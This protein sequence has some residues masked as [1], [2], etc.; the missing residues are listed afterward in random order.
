[1]KQYGIYLKKLRESKGYTLRDVEK[2]TGIS[3]AHLSQLEGS[4]VKQPSP[5]HLHKLAK[6]YE[7]EYKTLMETAGYPVIEDREDKKY[8]RLGK[9]TDEEEIELLNYLRFMRSRKK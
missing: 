8:G 3:N 4:R 9:I 7:V 2:I 6:A 1:M 5:I